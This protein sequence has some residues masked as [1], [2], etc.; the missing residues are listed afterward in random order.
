MVEW[1]LVD[2]INQCRR[3]N[4]MILPLG[5]AVGLTGSVLFKGGSDNDLDLILYPLKSVDTPYAP[6]VRKIVDF[7]DTT[8]SFMTRKY[9]CKHNLDGKLVIRIATSKG[10]VDLI[11]PSVR[12]GQRNDDIEMEEVP[13]GK[14]SP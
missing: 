4:Q 14:I 11:I 12:S 3:I 13:S 10:R 9:H 6:V 7:Y 5:Y 8:T 2:A 1:D